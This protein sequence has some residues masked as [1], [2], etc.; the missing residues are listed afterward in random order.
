MRDLDDKLA[1]SHP[2]LPIPEE[3]ILRTM[4][5]IRKEWLVKPLDGPIPLRKEVN[6]DDKTE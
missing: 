6:E 2:N 4:F 5:E 1:L 3:K